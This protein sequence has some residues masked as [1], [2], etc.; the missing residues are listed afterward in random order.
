MEGLS[1]DVVSTTVRAAADVLVQVWPGIERAT[2]LGRVLRD[3]TASLRE[4]HGGSLWGPHGHAVLF[5]A[6]R[7]LGECGLV[8]AAVDYWTE[9]ATEASDA[10]GDGH[11][12]TLNTRK[13]LAY[14]RGVAGDPVGAAAASEQLLADYLRVLGAGHPHTLGTR[15]ALARWQRQAGDARDRRW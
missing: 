14:C 13:D 3:C 12:D 15:R 8:G 2:E 7:S 6:G 11:P 1:I 5:R 4:C 10:L 9:M